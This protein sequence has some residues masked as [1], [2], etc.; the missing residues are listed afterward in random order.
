MKPAPLRGIMS[1]GML[2]AGDLD[3]ATHK[4]RLVSVPEEAKPGDRVL[5]KGVTPSEP[6][7]LKL[8]DFDKI[9]LNVKG[10]QVF[11]GELVLEVNS[12]AVTCDVAD[13]AGVH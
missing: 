2:L 8:K 7:E 4:C 5:F 10:G 12:K 11:C 9:S 1:S 13:G 6:R 3:E